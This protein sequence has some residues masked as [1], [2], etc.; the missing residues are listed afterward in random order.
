MKNASFTHQGKRTYQEDYFYDDISEQGLYILCDG[1]GGAAKGAE[2]SQLVTHTIRTM[3]EDKKVLPV[4]KAI[5][6][7]LVTTAS[8]AL[9]QKV[10]EVPEAEGMGTTLTMVY[11][12]R[13]GATLAHIGD[14]RI[15][16][17]KPKL[18]KYWRTKD[19]SHV[20]ELFD[21]GILK[22]EAAMASHPMNNR[23]TRALQGKKEK[24]NMGEKS[25]EADV[26]NIGNVEDGDL[27]FMCSDG[28]LEAYFLDSF[29]EVLVDSQ[30]ELKERLAKIESVCATNSNDNNTA[31]LIEVEKSDVVT[32]ETKTRLS[33]RQISMG[34]TDIPNAI[35]PIVAVN[36]E[37]NNTETEIKDTPRL[38]RSTFFWVILLTFVFLGILFFSGKIKNKTP[39]EENKVSQTEKENL[40]LTLDGIMTLL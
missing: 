37:Q 13:N 7:Q 23:I 29:L 1:V 35:V 34:A 28:V 14:S 19:H 22:S 27:F 20:Q 40:S 5:V 8:T 2:A 32:T 4:G 39:A 33:W 12:H 38:N 36:V 11:F 30:L 25:V 26:T 21:V 16:Y 31:I 17:I 24:D 10:Q 9:K 6:H 15:Y 3:V 18:G